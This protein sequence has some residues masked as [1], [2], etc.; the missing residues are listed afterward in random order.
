MKNKLSDIVII[1]AARTPIGTFNG[2][3]KK[4]SSDKLGSI[5]IKEALKQSKFIGDEIDE[6]IMGQVLTAGAGQNPARQAAMMAGINKEKTATAGT[7]THLKLY[8]IIF[9][10][11]CIFLLFRFYCNFCLVSFYFL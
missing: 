7:I 1:S 6:I 11:Y 4:M 9:Y 5:V 2:S 10:F 3:L 8:Y